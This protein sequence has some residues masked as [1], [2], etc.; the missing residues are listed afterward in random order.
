M[1][2]PTTAPKKHTA[3]GRRYS[4]AQKAQI[5]LDAEQNG[6]EEAVAKHGCSAHGRAWLRAAEDPPQGTHR[7][8]GGLRHSVRQFVYHPPDSLV[9]IGR[10]PFG[11]LRHV[12]IAPGRFSPDLVAIGRRP[13]A[14]QRGYR[15]QPPDG[16]RLQPV[17]YPSAGPPDRR[18]RALGVA[19]AAP[20]LVADTIGC[21]DSVRRASR[22]AR[23]SARACRRCGCRFFTS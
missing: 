19:S 6:V 8:F 16:R 15:L 21:T 4:P 22:P 20:R 23:W 10:R 13:F 1:T 14:Q 7:A 3:R 2:D 5:L 9:A 17:G 18:C 12:V 11:G